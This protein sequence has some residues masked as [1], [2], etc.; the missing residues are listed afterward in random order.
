[1]GQRV[2]L[3]SGSIVEIIISKFSQKIASEFIDFLH[4]STLYLVWVSVSER[5]AVGCK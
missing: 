1:M 5:V 4:E 3:K 2:I